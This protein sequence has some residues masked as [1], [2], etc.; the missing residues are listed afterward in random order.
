MWF[1]QHRV[2][3]VPHRKESEPTQGQQDLR[4]TGVPSLTAAGDT[5][6]GLTT[7]D[8]TTDNTW[9]LGRQINH[10]AS[11]IIVYIVLLPP[12]KAEYWQPGYKL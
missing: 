11:I 5:G 1:A 4:T 12:C 9:Q 6:M 2:D 7:M 3:R 10:A 8:R